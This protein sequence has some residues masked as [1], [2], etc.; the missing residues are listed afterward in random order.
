MVG[1]LNS[2]LQFVNKYDDIDIN[3]EELHSQFNRKT[4]SFF[5]KL[6]LY[7]TLLLIYLGLWERLID[8]GNI[9][10]YFEEFSNYWTSSLKG[11]PL[12]IHDFFYLYSNY[13]GKFHS[14]EIKDNS[15]ADEFLNTWQKKE[16]IFLVFQSVYKYALYPISFYP[17]KN[18]IRR[19]N[20][21]LEYGCGVAP[22][23][24][25]CLRF[26]IKEQQCFTIADIRSFSFHY[27]KY[28]LSKF[29]KVT[30]ID[31]PPHKP[32]QFPKKFDLVFL[33]TVIEHLPDPLEVLQ[34]ITNNLNDDAILIFD[35]VKSEGKGLDTIEALRQRKEVLDFI[36]SNYSLISGKFY[37]EKSMGTT[38]VKKRDRK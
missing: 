12:R 22:I 26:S 38:I 25:S 3:I 8:S 32:V 24:Q 35:F 17:Y 1:E 16:N 10:Y 6:K 18:Y 5:F 23:T 13:R 7:P 15:T 28:Q 20:Q 33:M 36:N 34:G 19:A 27:A 21:I 30:F 14:I 9:R 11:R 2:K 31:I 4:S 29:E 37:F